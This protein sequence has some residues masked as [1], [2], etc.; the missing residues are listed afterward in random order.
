MSAVKVKFKI[1]IQS[2]Y[3]IQNI[4]S[5]LIQLFQNQNLSKLVFS[6]QNMQTNITIFSL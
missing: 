3:Q 1:V 5:L 2:L 4:I 6:F